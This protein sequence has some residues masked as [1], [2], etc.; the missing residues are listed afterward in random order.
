MNVKNLLATTAAHET[1]VDIGS[2]RPTR[3]SGLICQGTLRTGQPVFIK[4]GYGEAAAEINNEAAVLERKG[5]SKQKVRMPNL[6]WHDSFELFGI[7]CQEAVPGVP[8]HIAAKEMSNQR[9]VDLVA[10]ALHNVSELKLDERT[11][12]AIGQEL[13]RLH[14]LLETERVDKARLLHL[15]GHRSPKELL[16]EIS[17]DLEADGANTFTHGDFCMPNLLIVERNDLAVVDWGKAGWAGQHKD[18]CALSGSL[19]RNGRG[20]CIRSLCEVLEIEYDELRYWKKIYSILDDFWH[21]YIPLVDVCERPQVST[22][23]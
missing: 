20:D 5:F 2:L 1:A 3:L 14:C 17:E 11:G 23:P 9:L 21:C 15:S 8:L 18:L 12:N 6:V 22:I 10:E 13:A 16:K 4:V 7:L 19:E